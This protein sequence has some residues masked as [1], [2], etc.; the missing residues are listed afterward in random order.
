MKTVRAL[1]VDDEALAR[2]RV[3][4]LLAQT[5]GVTVVGECSFVQLHAGAT[6]SNI[7]G[8]GAAIKRRIYTTTQNGYFA[9][10]VTNLN[11]NVAPFRVPLW[12]P[13]STIA[14]TATL[15]RVR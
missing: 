10:T 9:T 11:L 7:A 13:T 5:A 14:P 2:E 8:S 4:T 1:I 3:R 6:D 12:P 15:T